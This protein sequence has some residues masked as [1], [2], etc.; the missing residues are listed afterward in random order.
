MKPGGETEATLV[1][2]ILKLPK[3]PPSKEERESGYQQAG[4]VPLFGILGLGLGMTATGAAQ[5]WM[6]QNTDT[7]DKIVR[8]LQNS[9]ENDTDDPDPH[10][11]CMEQY[12]DDMD[13][14]KDAA[15]YGAWAKRACEETA[16]TAM[17]QCRRGLPLEDRRKLQ[18]EFR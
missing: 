2:K 6:D 8:S 13:K 17:A 10:Q 15:K 12:E 1:S 14:C 9:I 3:V 4:A 7:R 5:W 16:A 18:T 11:D